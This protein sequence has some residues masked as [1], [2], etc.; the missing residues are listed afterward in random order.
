MCDLGRNYQTTTEIILYPPQ[1]FFVRKQ[2]YLLKTWHFKLSLLERIKR[3]S[4]WERWP[5]KETLEKFT[6][7]QAKLVFLMPYRIQLN[8]QPEAKKKTKVRTQ[9][10]WLALLSTW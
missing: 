7:A 8:T 10:T 6:E 2:G 1:K 9:K 5:W 3:Q 4:K